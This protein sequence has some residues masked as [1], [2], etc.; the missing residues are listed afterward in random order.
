MK[1]ALRHLNNA[2]R[3]FLRTKLLSQQLS[4]PASTLLLPDNHSLNEEEQLLRQT[5]ADFA[6]KELTPN[7]WAV[8]KECRFSMA[9]IKKMGDLGLMGLNV[10]SELGGAGMDYMAY[11]IVMEEVSRGCA[12]AGVIVSA[13][14]SLYLAPL[15]KYAND[16]QAE[17]YVRPFVTGVT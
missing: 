2:S 16:E 6:A 7:A 3:D 4:R 10:S 13:H 1:S 5:C 15:E 8:D 17:K 11:A 14:N 12:T 9:T